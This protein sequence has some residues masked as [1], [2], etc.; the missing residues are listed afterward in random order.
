VV[1]RLRRVAT[2][3]DEGQFAEEDTCVRARKRARSDQQ[4]GPGP[5]HLP[6]DRRQE[7]LLVDRRRPGR[8]GSPQGGCRWAAPSCLAG[9]PRRGCPGSECGAHARPAARAHRVATS[10]RDKGHLLAAHRRGLDAAPSTRGGA[11]AGSSSHDDA[12]DR[13]R[14]GRRRGSRRDRLGRRT[15][16][17]T[18]TQRPANRSRPRRDAPASPAAQLVRQAHPP[19]AWSPDERVGQADPA[20]PRRAAAPGH[21]ER[22]APECPSRCRTR[23]THRRATNPSGR[24]AT[25]W[26][27]THGRTTA[28]RGRELRWAPRCRWRS[29]RSPRSPR[30]AGCW[31]WC[32][33]R[34]RPAASAVGSA[35]PEPR[36]ARADP[37][38]DLRAVQCACP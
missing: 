13:A 34:P 31:T 8:P 25:R 32:P 33:A 24:V 4:G 9:P 19:A 7:P 28:I 11:T 30:R 35:S 3:N 5:L 22:G 20:A 17:R 23:G 29:G 6:R 15:A 14:R 37:A 18:H 36:G 16:A 2:E 1:A 12:V 38:H 21:A 26:T 27:A 10:G